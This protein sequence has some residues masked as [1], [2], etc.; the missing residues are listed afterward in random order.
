[1]RGL[2]HLYGLSKIRASYD[3][4]FGF[5]CPGN[6]RGFCVR[7][8]DTS[9]GSHAM[10]VSPRMDVRVAFCS[11][12]ITRFANVAFTEGTVSL[13]LLNSSN[14]I[15]YQASHLFHWIELCVVWC[16]EDA[17]YLKKIKLD[18]SGNNAL[19]SYTLN[20]VSL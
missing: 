14:K 2:C 12:L 16:E 10:R 20:F 7:L 18:S 9:R 5:V 19:S 4:G 15:S 17:Y 6:P 3:R 8:E 1:M 13:D 11:D